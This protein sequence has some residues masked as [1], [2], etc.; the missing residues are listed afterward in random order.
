MKPAGHGRQLVH[1]PDATR[2]R[3]A[4]RR[5]ANYNQLNHCDQNNSHRRSTINSTAA[6]KATQTKYDKLEQTM[7]NSTI[8]ILLA[9]RALHCKVRSCLPR[10]PLQRPRPRA[11]AIAPCNWKNSRPPR[12]L[13]PITRNTKR[14]FRR[15]PRRTWKAQGSITNVAN[16]P[17]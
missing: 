3:R 10:T 5:E 12:R 13:G 6:I 11:R 15:A 1:E 7:I 2:T 8:A 17:T 16:L 14:I 9:R 4:A